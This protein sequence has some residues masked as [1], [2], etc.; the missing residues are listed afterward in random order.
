MIKYVGLSTFAHFC[1]AILLFISLLIGGSTSENEHKNEKKIETTEVKLYDKS[2]L[3]VAKNSNF[4]SH[5]KDDCERYY[6]GIGIYRNIYGFVIEVIKGYPGD[7]LGLEPGDFIADDNLKGEPGTEVTF[8][9]KKVSGEIV[10]YTIV[11][12]KIC[13]I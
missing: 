13:I 8:K 7:Y 10:E 5:M 4:P 12:D 3:I 9:V 6:G 1:I 2:E 11:R